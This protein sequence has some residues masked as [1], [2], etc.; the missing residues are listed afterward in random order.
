MSERQRP[1]C[2]MIRSLSAPSFARQSVAPPSGTQAGVPGAARRVSYGCT[3]VVSATDFLK[4]LGELA[5]K[6]GAA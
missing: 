2:L 5:A 6:G 1:L 4:Q 3:D